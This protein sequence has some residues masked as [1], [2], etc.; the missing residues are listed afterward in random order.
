M[1]AKNILILKS[2]SGYN[3]EVN[4]KIKKEMLYFYNK[5]IF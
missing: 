5:K 3:L 4:W 2:K 1:K